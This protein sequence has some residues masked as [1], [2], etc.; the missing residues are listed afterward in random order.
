MWLLCLVP[1]PLLGRDAT[2]QAIHSYLDTADVIHLA[3]HAVYSETMPLN[4]YLTLAPER[5]QERRLEMGDIFALDL[6]EANLVVLSAC[7]TAMGERS[8]GDE[9]VALNRA[10]LAAGTP[11]LVSTLWKIDDTASNE[12]MTRFYC[13]LQNG[14]SVDEALR[15][16]QRTTIARYPDPFYWA[17]F[18]LHSTQVDELNMQALPSTADPPVCTG[19]G[20]SD[21]RS[22]TDS[23]LDISQTILQI[24][25][26]VQSRSQ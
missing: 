25:E 2:E 13:N 10:F 17:A 11:A 12:L 3:T 20:Y 19:F 1:P 9:V 24:W 23:G 21:T 22:D 4:S 7:E 8:L 5:G 16:A 6:T 15:A 14:Q 18:A 26:R